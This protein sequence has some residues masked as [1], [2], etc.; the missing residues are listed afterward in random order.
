MYFKM[1][2]V[3]CALFSAAIGFN[4]AQSAPFPGESLLRP[5]AGRFWLSQGFRLGTE[6]TPWKLDEKNTPAPSDWN[7]VHLPL[8][9]ANYTHS[10]I[11]TA[12]LRVVVEEL[13]SKTTLESYAKRWLKDYHQYGFRVL[14]TKPTKLNG[15]PTLMYD[16]TSNTRDVQ[17]RQM[18]QV[19]KGRA[20]ILTCSD[21]RPRFAQVLPACNAMAA[22]LIWAPSKN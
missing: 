20:V 14:A 9:G 2:I 21:Q 1:P 13:K 3:L 7:D 12:R 4:K 15:V 6:G 5:Q 10:L 19:Q 8:E 11:P 16:L 22:N 18:I 17:L